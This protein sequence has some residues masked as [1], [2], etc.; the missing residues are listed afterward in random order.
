MNDLIK[1]LTG[2]KST[3]G[4]RS[5]LMV[6]VIWL[7][8]TAQETQKEVEAVKRKVDRIEY[9]MDYGSLPAT[10]QLAQAGRLHGE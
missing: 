3:V 9:R 8:W 2:P 7:A 6:V 10:N 5:V 4:H 1:I